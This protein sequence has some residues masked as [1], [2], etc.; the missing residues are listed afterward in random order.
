LKLRRIFMSA[1]VT[2]TFPTELE[3]AISAKAVASG[4]D[5]KDYIL[6]IA[7]KDSALPTLRDLF[8]DVRADMEA[9]G[10]TDEEWE[11]DVDDAV[12]EVRAQRRA[13]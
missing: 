5:F 8:A 6:Y 13:R 1:T 3:Q 2:I 10:I 12:A 7:E 4:K 11:K 9:R